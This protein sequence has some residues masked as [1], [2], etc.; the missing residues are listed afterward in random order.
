MPDNHTHDAV[1]KKMYDALRALM[2]EKD[3]AD[4]SITDIVSSARVSRM[5]F[6]RNYKDKRDILIGRFEVILQGY[7]E[8]FSRAGGLLQREL[9]DF[10][11]NE[12]K[13]SDLLRYIRKAGLIY[14]AIDVFR[15]T[16]LTYYRDVFQWPLDEPGVMLVVYQRMGLLAGVLGFL[17][18]HPQDADNTLLTDAVLAA[19]SEDNVCRNR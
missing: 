4:I 12:L 13:S 2:D 15:E 1:V 10:F 3:Y 9:W 6:Y 14:S 8:Q 11:F 19:I 5:A 18:D 7:S 16:F 17:A